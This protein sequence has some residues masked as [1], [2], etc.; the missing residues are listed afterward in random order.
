MYPNIIPNTTPYKII[1]PVNLNIDA[2]IPLI[3]PSL[4]ASI[5]LLVI[6]LANPVDGTIKPHL[7]ILKTLSNIPIPV[8]N[9]PTNIK[10]QNVK[11]V[12]SFI[13]KPHLIKLFIIISPNTPIK[14]PLIRL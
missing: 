1:L 10:T 2:P 8:N 13:L 11:K 5:A 12:E 6:V 14:P 7:H 4:L 3:K 9:D